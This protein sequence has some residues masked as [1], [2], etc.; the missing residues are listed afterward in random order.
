MG[1]IPSVRVERPSNNKAVSHGPMDAVATLSKDLPSSATSLFIVRYGPQLLLCKQAV[2]A[3]VAGGSST[4]GL[5]LIS[6]LKFLICES[7]CVIWGGTSFLHMPTS[8]LQYPAKNLPQKASC[9]NLVHQE[10]REEDEAELR[11]GLSMILHRIAAHCA[12]KDSTVWPEAVS[13]QL[14]ITVAEPARTAAPIPMTGTHGRD[15][16]AHGDP[17]HV[18][19]MLAVLGLDCW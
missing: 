9:I 5:L 10:W 18:G 4:A 1:R 6:Q 15:A 3:K 7:S 8:W 17:A 19:D 14:A 13:A 12:R 16:N 2:Q 11:A